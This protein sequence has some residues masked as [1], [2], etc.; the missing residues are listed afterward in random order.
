[1][2]NLITVTRCLAEGGSGYGGINLVTPR[3]LDVVD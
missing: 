1:M 3:A 2:P